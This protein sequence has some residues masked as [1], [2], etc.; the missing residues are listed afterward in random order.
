MLKS[1]FMV[2]A[3]GVAVDETTKNPTIFS[4]LDALTPSTFPAVVPRMVVLS[5]IERDRTDPDTVRLRL[6]VKL[7]DA[8]LW[9]FPLEAGFSGRSRCNVLITLEGIVVPG[10]GRLL[11]SLEME[12]GNPVGHYDITV[13]SAPARGE[14]RHYQEEPQLSTTFS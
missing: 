11:F 4:L 14:S 12:E 8:L 6:R 1:R 13:N 3:E 9:E 7:E 5:Y 2:C 10:P